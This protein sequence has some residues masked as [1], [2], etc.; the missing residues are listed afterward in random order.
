M[1]LTLVI[2]NFFGEFFSRNFDLIIEILGVIVGLFYLYYEYK[3]SS[4]LWIAGIIM[5]AISLSVYYRAGLYADFGI[6]VYYLIAAVYGWIYW[7]YKGSKRREQELLITRMP[8]KAWLVG[9]AVFVV[10]EV[11]I[12]Y[13]LVNFTDS[14]VPG[15]DTFTTA[16][17]IVGMWL[18]AKKYVEQWLSWI[19]VDIVSSGLY[20]YKEIYFYAALYAL[21]AMIAVFGYFKWI[22]LM[23]NEQNKSL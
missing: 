23:K 9:A 11:V 12:Y 13:I 8:V 7:K 15:W 6:N 3:A 17:S 21:Y 20:I 1:D 19:L 18:L 10:A 16:L 5:P 14:N 4:L 2:L 22:K